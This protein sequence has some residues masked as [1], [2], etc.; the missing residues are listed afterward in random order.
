MYIKR[1]HGQEKLSQQY[2]N[3]AKGYAITSESNQKIYRTFFKINLPIYLVLTYNSPEITEVIHYKTFICALEL[4]NL[5]NFSN[6][7]I[8]F[9]EYRHEFFN[10]LIPR[11]EKLIFDNLHSGKLVACMSSI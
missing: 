11:S 8:S 1:W 3:M 7:T 10:T 4:Y 9:L 6:I 5:P 2:E